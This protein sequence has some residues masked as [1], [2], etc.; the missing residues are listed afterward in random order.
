MDRTEEIRNTILE[1]LKE[2]YGASTAEID[3]SNKIH[4][5]AADIAIG[6]YETPDVYRITVMQH[7]R[8]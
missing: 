7:E 2:K 6:T 8:K 3:G 1:T 4:F 5:S